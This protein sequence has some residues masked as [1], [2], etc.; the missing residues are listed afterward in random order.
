VC[1]VTGAVARNGPGLNVFV[2]K[3]CPSVFGVGFVIGACKNGDEATG[4]VFGGKGAANKTHAQNE[5]Q[6]LGAQCPLGAEFFEEWIDK[7]YEEEG[8]PQGHGHMTE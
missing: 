1:D 2:G 5:A 8:E 7:K 3:F 4:Y 6:F